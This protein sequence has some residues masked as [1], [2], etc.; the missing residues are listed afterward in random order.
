MYELPRD[1]KLVESEGHGVDESEEHLLKFML[2]CISICGDEL[3]RCEDAPV[4]TVTISVGISNKNKR[5]LT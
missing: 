3:Y 1:E 2:T 5:K 4:A